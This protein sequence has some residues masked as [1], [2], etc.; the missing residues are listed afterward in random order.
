MCCFTFRKKQNDDESNYTRQSIKISSKLFVTE[1][2]GN[3]YKDYEILDCI[4]Q[5]SYGKVYRAKHIKTG[6]MR[7]IKKIYKTSFAI[8]KEEE[9]D[10][11]KEISML[12]QLDHPNILKIFEF[13]NTKNNLF[14][15]SEYLTGGELFKKII[16]EKHFSEKVAAHVMRQ[17]FSAVQFC[18]INN[19][20]HRDLKPENI[21]IESYEPNRAEF[22]TIRVI[23]FG[24]SEYKKKTML[25]EKIGSSYYIAPEVLNNNY[26]EK[27][28]VWSCG[29]ILFILLCGYSPFNG[30]TE[31][32]I[33]KKVKIGKFSMTDSIWQE[34]SN[35]AK[36]LIEKLLNKN[37][38][39]RL[40]AAEALKHEWFRKVE[41]FDRRVSQGR[42]E[43]VFNNLKKF[44]T[45]QKLQ[46]AVLSFLV[47][48][49]IQKEEV[50]E[51]RRVF[52]S[53]N[54][55][56]DGRLTKS[57][58][59]EGLKLLMESKQAKNETDE[60]M[61]NID[62]NSSGFIEYEEF[63]T[64]SLDKKTLL[65][66][67]NLRFAFN[68]FD[69]DSDGKISYSELKSILGKAPMPDNQE[70]SD[71]LFKDM[72]SKI[73]LNGDGEI[74]YEEFKLMMYSLLKVSEGKDAD[75]SLEDSRIK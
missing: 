60:L 27:C 34:V 4:G 29:V 7:A 50:I 61:K 40:S 13:Y 17:L 48:N 46:Q 59:Q 72:I 9:Q 73:D 42:L 58:L 24:T 32:S 56:G 57:E 10:L 22:F 45:E 49:F 70:I 54:Q 38:E 36:D 30:R 5:G 2:S 12:K 6:E 71:S 44:H 33:L 35:E 14:I 8:S 52:L 68:A 65:T 15:V 28:D 63:I 25:K 41:T 43:N 39:K 19:I 26:N 64:A 3:I 23:D 31:E 53:F 47:H 74:C 20:I 66:E 75:I 37:I 21:I 55:N 67:E 62:F 18:H 16:E 11:I 51:L 69:K 1:S